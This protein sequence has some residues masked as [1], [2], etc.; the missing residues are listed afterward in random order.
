MLESCLQKNG[1][2]FFNQSISFR[3]TLRAPNKGKLSI[4][5]RFLNMAGS[6]RISDKGGWCLLYGHEMRK[7]I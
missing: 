2:F 6:K 5:L 4:Q 1:D 3:I 7:S